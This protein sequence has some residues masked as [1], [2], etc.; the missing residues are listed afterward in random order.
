MQNPSSG[1]LSLLPVRLV[2]AV[3]ATLCCC[4][5]ILS[6]ARIG[7]AKLLA[8]YAVVMASLPAA[9]EAARLTPSDPEAHRNRAA[10]LNNLRLFS[11]ARNAQELATSLRPKDDY[12]WLELGLLKDELEDT[13]GALAAFN[14][15]VR[16]APYYAHTHW[17]RG[18]L[19][20]R[21]GRY[22]E[23]FADLRQAAA[24]NRDYLPNLIDLAWALSHGDPRT[25]AQLV[26]INDDRTR[27]AF[28]RFL[29]RQGKATEALDQYRLAAASVSEENQ[30]DLVRQLIAAKAFREA[31][32]IWTRSVGVSN[33]KAPVLY[34]GG[35][36]GP[37][38]LDEV[39]FGWRVPREVDG[40]SMSLDATQQHTGAKSLRL[41][42][43]GN[44]TPG[45]LLLSQTVVVKAQQRYRVNFAV[46]T[47][48]IV[49]GG[50]PVITASD[51]TSGQL[52]GKSANFP[53]AANSWQVL[54]FEFTTLTKTDAVIL[55][56]Q[57]N[58]CSSAPCPIFGFV[59]LDSISIEE[60][61]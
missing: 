26:E 33:D 46:S 48:D 15:A 29:A 6:S 61:K 16:F 44:S 51:A 60:V 40:L 25:T 30:R 27:I 36:E 35:F 19:L 43:N 12:L 5:L 57:R 21:M 7:Y 37:L 32:E 39:G 28:A 10:V 58:N 2:I 1:F 42:F 17:Q 14:Q 9:N 34:D 11:D 52:L 20:L 54:S 50:L 18:N 22:Q 56:L 41:Q 53:Q 49:T 3:L 31:F 38:S 55:S 47:K 23:A 59:W 24:S 45:V 13:Q 8:K 4:L